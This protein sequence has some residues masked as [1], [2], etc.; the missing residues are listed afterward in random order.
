MR[1]PLNPKRKGLATMYYMEAPVV[2]ARELRRHALIEEAARH[3]LVSTA[4][5]SSDPGATPTRRLSIRSI[6]G[7][8]PR[9]WQGSAGFRQPM[10]HVE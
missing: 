10:V 7:P 6:R 9:S 3:R 2:R 5:S 1:T 4:T 8:L